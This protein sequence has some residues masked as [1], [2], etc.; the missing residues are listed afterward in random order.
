MMAGRY[1]ISTRHNFPGRHT[2]GRYKW[3]FKTR[4]F[5]P[6]HKNG[7][8][9][10][11]GNQMQLH[12]DQDKISTVSNSL[13]K[14]GVHELNLT[15]LIRSKQFKKALDVG[16]NIGYFTLLLADRSAHV[17]AFE[18]DPV[19][20]A[21]LQDNI[22]H[23]N[24]TNL[25]LFNKALM[26]KPG[27]VMLHKNTGNPGMHRVYSSVYNDGPVVPVDA[28]RLDDVI[29]DEIDFIKMDAEGAEY[30]ILKGMPKILS[31]DNMIAFEFHAYT[32][33]EAGT[34]PREMFDYVK[35]FGYK[36]RDIAGRAVDIDKMIDDDNLDSPNYSLIF[37]KTHKM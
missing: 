29:D 12:D 7:R 28:V 1:T 32:V 37:V 9:V 20:F 35:E 24:K 25:S 23:N 10:I 36:I 18:P 3:A 21:I 17:Y 33:R 4:L 8:Y 19:N 22:R 2:L 11:Y 26:S 31:Q 16:A 5:P 14:N 6:K 30:D 15:R 34:D 27:K 13:K